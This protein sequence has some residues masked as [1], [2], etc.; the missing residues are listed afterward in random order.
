MYS[1]KV[2]NQILGEIQKTLPFQL[3][4]YSV[5]ECRQFVEYIDEELINLDL[6]KSASKRGIRAVKNI[7]DDG[8]IFKSFA[9]QQVYLSNEIQSRIENERLLCKWDANYWQ[10]RYYLIKN[11]KGIYVPYSPLPAQRIWRRMRADLN[12]KK[13]PLNFLDLKGRQQGDTTDKQGMIEHRLQF[14]PD[15]DALIASKEEKDTGKMSMKLIESFNRQPFWLKPE[16]ESFQTGDAYRFDNGSFLDLGWGTQE[17]LGK[18]QTPMICHLSEIAS[19][20]YPKSAIENA[21]MR[22]MHETEWQMK[23]LEGTAETRDDWF[24]NKVKEVISQM[25]RGE[26]SWV[27]NFIAWFF[28][29]DLYPTDTWMLGRNVAF[30]NWIPKVETIAMAKM[31]ENA[32]KSWKYAREELGSNW[33]MDREQMFYYE[34]EYQQAEKEDRLAEF[35]SQMPTTVD[36]AFQHA[37]KTLY[38]IQLIEDYSQKAHKLIPEVYKLRGDP[39]E[40]SPQY[41]P[42]PDEILEGG[43]T[44]E[45]ICNWN[46]AIPASIFYL[47]QIKFDGWDTFDPINKFLIWEHPRSDF[48]YGQSVDTSDGLGRELSDDAIINIT[49]IGTAESRDKQVLEFASPEIPLGSM[50]PFTLVSA[51]YYSNSKASQILVTIECN[52]GFELQNAIIQRG[53]WNLYKRL[54]DSS[55]YQDESKIQ[56]FGFWTDKATRPALVSHFHQ[57]FIGKHYE[58]YSIILLA[59]IRDLQKVR[60]PNSELGFSGEKIL[61]KKDNRVLAAAINLFA[62]HRREIAGY[63][64]KTWEERIRVEQNIVSIKTFK[65]F[66]YEKDFDDDLVDDELGMGINEYEIERNLDEDFS[67][68]RLN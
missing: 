67:F 50:W 60:K 23:F 52:K 32:V 51:T 15:T 22:A 6:Y 62:I 54:D 48:D 36:Q 2:S 26:T 41:W 13:L 1:E 59:E 10:D 9:H 7:I 20:K 5:K 34:L 33:Q 57:F 18:G 49:R 55:P 68:G 11:I 28:R 42:E 27:F 8:T 31:A 61:G 65:G 37:G 43:K 25:Q 40:I 63:E 56:K 19:F 35:L 58:I 66:D 24:H 64:K 14:F 21:L 29:R 16:L 12:E 44:I 38:K 53:W 45:I 39:S 3:Q 4:R 17:F 46:S 30:A 47:V